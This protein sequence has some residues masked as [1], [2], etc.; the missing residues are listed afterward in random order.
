MAWTP[1]IHQLEG[2]V[3]QQSLHWPQ[4]IPSSPPT[5]NTGEPGGWSLRSDVVLDVLG[6]V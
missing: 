2:E 6:K 1:V 5:S 3:R 4:P